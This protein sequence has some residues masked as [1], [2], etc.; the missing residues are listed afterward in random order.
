P[1]RRTMKLRTL[2]PILLLAAA[3]AAAQTATLCQADSQ[4]GRQQSPIDIT[5]AVPAPLRR[6]DYG[7]PALQGRACST[8]HNIQVNVPPGDSIVV[9]GTSFMLEEFHFHWPAEHTLDGHSY[10]V[11]IHMVHKRAGRVVV[12][13]T[14]VEEG[15][16]NP[17]WDSIWATFPRIANGR[18]TVTVT[19]DI[20]ELFA[21]RDLNAERIYTYCGSLTTGDY[22]EGVT[23]LVR[24]API[25]MST[26]QIALLRRA[27][28]CYSRATQPLNGRPIRYR[29]AGR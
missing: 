5:G 7:Y 22:E 24:A 6:L 29:R 23:W 16:A 12:L 8:G 21:I 11:E 2:V 28:T 15:A 26:A 27:M 10:P 1:R 3:P 9:D 20:R 19:V 13:A 17:A 18:D 14:W 25:R 4:P